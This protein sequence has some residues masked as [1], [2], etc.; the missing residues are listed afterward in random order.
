MGSLSRSMEKVQSEHCR[1]ISCTRNTFCVSQD[2]FR[3]PYSTL[4]CACVFIHKLCSITRRM[5]VS[6][7]VCDSR[8]LYSTRLQFRRGSQPV[9]SSHMLLSRCCCLYQI[10]TVNRRY[11][12][13]AV[14]SN[15][16]RC[17]QPPQLQHGPERL[18]GG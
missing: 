13:D 9:N 3:S 10:S 18:A 11:S 4:H 16:P 5:C 15:F 7:S 6:E 2:S 8:Q 14:C 1:L 17:L 12:C